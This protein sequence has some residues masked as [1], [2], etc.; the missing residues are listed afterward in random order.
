MAHPARHRSRREAAAATFLFLPALGAA[1][2]RAARDRAPRDGDAV[3]ENPSLARLVLVLRHGEKGAGEP[4]NPRLSAAGEARAR[5]LA[6]MLRAA[7]PTL[8][9]ASEYHRTADT[10]A[11]LAEACGVAVTQLPAREPARW[12]AAL[13]RL[14]PGSLAVVCGHSNTVPD[15]AQ[16][17]GAV[18]V[19]LEDGPA[20]PQFKEPVHDRLV[21]IVRAVGGGAATALEL[22]YGT[23]SGS[24]H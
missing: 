9:L 14:P 4:S 5:Q 7:Q 17:L 2:G 22:R 23:P 20:G 21:L 24:D 19:D 13:D 12:L 18:L 16:R 1:L 10:L 11:P 8:L 15:L 3:A 6:E